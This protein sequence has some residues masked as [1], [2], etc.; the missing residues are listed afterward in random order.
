MSVLDVTGKSSNVGGELKDESDVLKLLS[1]RDDN[2]NDEKEDEETDEEKGSKKAKK[3]K[4]DDDES[5]NKDSDT[6]DEPELKLEEDEEPIPD[7]DELVDPPFAKK[8]ILKEFP[9]LFKKFPGIEKSIYRERAYA[10]HFPT[11]ADAKEAVERLEVLK[12]FEEK[13]FSGDLSSVLGA[14]K[15]QEPAKYGEYV[16]NYLENLEKFDPKAYKHVSNKIVYQIADYIFRAGENLSSEELKA[17]GKWLYEQAFGKG[18]GQAPT[19]FAGENSPNPESEKLK[20][21][22]EEFARQRF[23]TVRNDLQSRTDN[24]LKSTINNN[25][26]PRSQMS[27]YVK[28]QA[29]RD[30]LEKLDQV[31]SADGRF[32]SV[33][34]NLWKRASESNYSPESVNKIRNAYLSK[35]KASL[36][37]VLKLVRNE[38]LKGLGKS[39]PKQN[40]DDEQPKKRLPIGRSPSESNKGSRDKS[41]FDGGDVFK[42]L[43][44]ND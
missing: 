3:E 26:D 12:G 1:S 25:I 41:K 31:V 33:L 36:P 40:E 6:G 34:D 19:K 22:K 5:D 15:E 2:E 39:S 28:R 37:E 8:A 21:E 10:E 20:K 32:K 38:A 42:F 16:D 18:N 24:V 23:E 11:V 17:S 13:V 9:E 44:R 7:E 29:V 4:E 43:S 30:C 14:L 27:D 35:C